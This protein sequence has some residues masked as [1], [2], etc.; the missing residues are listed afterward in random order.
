MVGKTCSFGRQRTMQL[1][2]EP[3]VSC[4]MSLPRGRRKWFLLPTTTSS[5]LSAPLERTE[6]LLLLLRCNLLLVL[7]S[8]T[9]L[10]PLR[11][12]ALLSALAGG[13]GLVALG[14]HLLLEDALALFLRLGLVDLKSCVSSC[15]DGESPRTSL[16]VRVQP[17]RACA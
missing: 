5:T 10:V 15:R 3:F 2:S 17:E 11:R 16:D 6:L 8:S 1:F 12:H 4:S 14:L 9:N 13:L 7:A